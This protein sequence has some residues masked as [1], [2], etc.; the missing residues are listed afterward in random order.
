LTV[1]LTITTVSLYGEK[2]TRPIKAAEPELNSCCSCPP[3]ESCR[4]QINELPNRCFEVF[5]I[6]PRPLAGPTAWTAMPAVQGMYRMAFEKRATAERIREAIAEII[7]APL[8]ADKDSGVGP[9]VP[10]TEVHVMFVSLQTLHEIRK[11]I[12]GCQACS[13]RAETP[14]ESILHRVSGHDSAVTHYILMGPVRCP[15]CLGRVITSTLIE[16]K[17]PAESQHSTTPKE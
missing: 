17:P 15:R 14:F 5:V 10:P 9:S 6:R 11:L 13:P 7:A 12:A 1:R 2:M 3:G 4:V 8:A 16:S